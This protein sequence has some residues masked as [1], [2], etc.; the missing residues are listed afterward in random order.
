[1]NGPG[2]SPQANAA[3]ELDGQERL[4]WLRLIRTDHVGPLLFKDLLAHCG[5]ASRAIDALPDLALRG[6]AR[7]GIRI[8]P[9][10]DAERELEKADAFGARYVALGEADYPKHLVAVDAP[11]PLLAFKGDGRMAQ[12]DLV[13]IVGA[14]NCSLSGA[15]FAARTAEE[16]GACGYGI[17][18]GLAR[19]IDAAAHKASLRTGTIAVFAGGLDCVYPPEHG[20]LVDDIL[21][22]G[23]AIVSEM[24]FGLSPRGRDFPRRNRIVSGMSLGVV[25]IEAAQRSGTLHTARFALE[26][27]REIFAVPGS[28]LDP[29]SEGCNRLIRQ[30][31]HLITETRHITE[32]L[33]PITGRRDAP[34]F[35]FSETD[36]TGEDFAD[37]RQP[38]RDRV[39][40]ALG[41]APV[42]MDELIRHTGL[43]ARTVQLI[44][45][46][47][48]LANRI[49][50]HGNQMV[51]LQL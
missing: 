31:A 12:S 13:A 2:A 42:G 17:A 33:A 40:S 39:L 3:F 36:E 28:P 51:S 46:E 38:D 50:R 47:L 7:R 44:L 29:R 49:E 5:T 27:N 22:H 14:R 41:K 10:A 21:D 30:G 11:P 43:P 1:M 9:Q 48:D 37:P 45:L 4:A 15:K 20:S 24:P 8:Y 26:Q 32:S 23:G 34:S 16:L 35:D 6:G 18:S 25:V 19:G